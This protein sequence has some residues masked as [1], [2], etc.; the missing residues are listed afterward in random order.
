MVGILRR[1]IGLRGQRQIDL[2]VYAGM[3]IAV[4]VAVTVLCGI[5]RLP[6]TEQ[7]RL[8]I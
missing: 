4:A 1:V 6:W 7:G 3:P 8:A 5:A 2:A